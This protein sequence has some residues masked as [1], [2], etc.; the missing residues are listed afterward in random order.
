MKK[1]LL[2]LIAL[3]AIVGCESTPADTTK[4]PIDPMPPVEQK[5]I[6][7][8]VDESRLTEY[9]VIYSI[10]P[11]NK[12]A[13]YYCD[14][15]SKARWESA[16][17]NDVKAE[18]DKALRDYASWTEATYE[19]VCEQMLF[20][21][22]T[23]EF[24]SDAGYRADT[25]FVIYTFYWTEDD[26]T[27][28]DVYVTEFRTPS[29]KLSSEN[30]EITFEGVDPYE[31][32]VKC[33]PTANVE[34][35]YYYF[36]ETTKVEA[37][38]AELEDVNAYMSYH[39]MNVGAKKSGEQTLT[40]KG[41][42]PETSY[43]ALVMAVDKSG[44]RMQ[45]SAVQ[46]TEAVSQISRIE[47]ELFETLLGEWSGVQTITDGYAEPMVNEFSVSIV[48]GV[49]D[50]DYNYRDN[51]QLLALVD[52]WCQ[53]GYYSVTDL[54][55]YEIED[56]DLKWGPKWVLD[57]AEGDVI[58]MDG[59]ARNAVLG[60]FFFGNS[61]MFSGDPATQSLTLDTTFSVTLSEDGNT[62]TIA[63]PVAGNYPSL[64][65]NLDGF[66]WMGYYYGASDIVLTRK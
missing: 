1:L 52:G 9:Q 19:E 48:R 14:V 10:R 2:S 8:T 56:A 37:M 60:W 6:V 18:Y 63:S 49:E 64:A 42:K 54:V 20:K 5:G 58:T 35:Y 13:H 4:E 45:T 65:Y 23:E 12:E 66:G 15:M 3:A 59:H 34:R 41:L 33:V 29:H 22:D 62:L 17:I 7:V 26:I 32:T 40:E 50:F 31:M 55:E 61:F 43:T 44:Y 21:G 24:I 53:I 46:V 39:A 25:D 51:N 57:I 47:S 11:D 38:L 16:D 28:D 30:V 36:A 27:M